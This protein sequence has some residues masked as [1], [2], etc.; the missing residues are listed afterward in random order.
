MGYVW[1][2]TPPFRGAMSENRDATDGYPL[3]EALKR[4]ADPAKWQGY[5]TVR[6]A[7]RGRR[8]RYSMTLGGEPIAGWAAAEEMKRSN[9]LIEQRERAWRD[10]CLDLISRLRSGELIATGLEEPLTLHRA[11]TPIPPHL[12][13]ALRPDFKNSAAVGGG[14]RISAILVRRATG[15]DQE[16][17]AVSSAV[18][19]RPDSDPDAIPEARPPGRPSI[20][21]KIEAE[22]RRR[23]AAGQLRDTLGAESKVLA[24]WAQTTHPDEGPPRAK[25]IERRLGRLYQE[26]KQ[27]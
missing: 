1:P 16:R 14:L 3:Q 11:P 9:A 22:L 13:Q 18:E 27:K 20:M 4:F 8:R 25:S 19:E 12:W 21:P 15:A 23:A 26:L 10:L 5:E 7:A 2:Q 24:R 6:Q 17:T